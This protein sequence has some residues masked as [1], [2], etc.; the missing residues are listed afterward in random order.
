MEA[1]ILR[2]RFHLLGYHKYTFDSYNLISK[3]H[4][5]N[6]TLWRKG[7][8][9]EIMQISGDTLETLVKKIESEENK[10]K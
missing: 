4:I 9:I 2:K 7:A 1:E 6:I 5:G 10:L 8:R 3:D